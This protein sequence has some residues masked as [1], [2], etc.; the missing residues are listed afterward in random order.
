[1]NRYKSREQAF[2]FLFESLF[3]NNDLNRLTE[4]S[5]AHQNNEKLKVSDFTKR[6]FEGVY[7]NLEKIDE[8]INKNTKNWSKQRLSKVSLCILRLAIY[9]MLF[10]DDIPISVSINEAVELAKKYGSTEESS[11]VNGVLSGVNK[12]VLGMGNC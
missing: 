12:F 11:Y 5:E 3:S 9:E 8:H 7:K 2:L 10:E 6:L 4:L 1:M